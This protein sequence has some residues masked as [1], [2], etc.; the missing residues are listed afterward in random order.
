ME[1]GEFICNMMVMSSSMN[2]KEIEEDQSGSLIPM[3]KE[4]N[5]IE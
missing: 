3:E 2:T 5:L 4:E 1:D